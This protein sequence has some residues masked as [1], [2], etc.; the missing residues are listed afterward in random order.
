MGNI[1]SEPVQSSQLTRD[2]A[3][4][5]T[6][7]MYDMTDKEVKEYMSIHSKNGVCYIEF[8]YQQIGMGKE[9]FDMMCQK[10]EQDKIKIKREILLQRIRGTSKSPFD[11]EDLDIINDNRRPPIQEDILMKKFVLNIYRKLNK[12]IPYI[13]GIDC[14]GG[15]GVGSDNTAIA[16]VDPSDLTTIATLVTPYLDAVESA[17]IIVELTTKYVPRAMLCIERNNL[18]KA[19]IAILV[20]TP[21]AG[22]IYFDATKVLGDDG[23][24]KYNSKGYLEV[25]AEKR[26]FW[27][28][29]TDAKSRDI[30]M[31][32]ILTYQVK[33]YKERF[34]ARELIDDLN[35][36]IVKSNG[37]IEAAPKQHD[38]VVM[39]YNIAMYVYTHGT[40]ISNWGIVKGMKYDSIY[41]EK[42]KNGSV[43]YKEIY[44]SLPDDMKAIF[45]TPNESIDLLTHEQIPTS[46]ET[47]NEIYQMIQ[48]Q[49]SRKTNIVHSEHGDIVVK[50]NLS[51]SDMVNKAA[52]QGNNTFSSDVFDICDLLNS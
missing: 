41:K 45:P 47:N 14:A 17:K 32:E 49:Q 34:I 2:N 23:M 30:M 6:E 25:E 4:V 35:N 16:I 13:V 33:H 43:S 18:G 11:V 40:K 7:H 5:F 36:L 19:I 21:I 20:R 52:F 12:N 8:M 1:D 28:V 15:S 26:R 50:D 9:Y 48:A 10:L 3:A 51:A 24:D 31:G 27:G 29:L 22:N 37:R 42:E 46:H 38:D 39:A 44:A